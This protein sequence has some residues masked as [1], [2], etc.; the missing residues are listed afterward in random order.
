MNYLKMAVKSLSVNRKKEKK[1][2][3]KIHNLKRKGIQ[4]IAAAT[5][6]KISTFHKSTFIFPSLL[7]SRNKIFTMVF[8]NVLSLSLILAFMWSEEALSFSSIYLLLTLSENTLV[9]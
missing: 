3:V 5:A 1:K 8:R 4:T 9:S 2:I 6:T 7:L